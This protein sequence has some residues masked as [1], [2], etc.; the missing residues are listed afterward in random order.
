MALLNS[1]IFPLQPGN[2]ATISGD[3]GDVVYHA[4]ERTVRIRKVEGSNPFRSTKNRRGGE[5]VAFPRLLLYS[6]R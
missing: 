4:R 2:V 3:F 6:N 1:V 5:T